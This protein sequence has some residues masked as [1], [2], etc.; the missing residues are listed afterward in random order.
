MMSN[1]MDKNRLVLTHAGQEKIDYPGL[2][3][4]AQWN[5]VEE[6][7]ES[8]QRCFD[9]GG[10]IGLFKNF[11]AQLED[12]RELATHLILQIPNFGLGHLL[13]RKVKDLL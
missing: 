7:Q 2:K 12:F 10:F 5:P 13:S 3:D 11:R 9:E 4:I 1:Q 8:L 6:T